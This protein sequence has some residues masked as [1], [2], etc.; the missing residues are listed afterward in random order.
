MATSFKLSEDGKSR[1]Y[2]DIPSSGFVLV[3]IAIGD[4]TLNNWTNNILCSWLE[5]CDT[6]DF[7]LIAIVDNLISLNSKYWKK[8]TWQ[9]L[10]IPEY[11]SGLNSKIKRVCYVDT[12]ILISPIAPDI[13]SKV[14]NKEI[15][16]V[17]IFSNLPYERK[18]VLDRISYFR[19][20]NSKGHYPLDSSLYM[21]VKQ[22]YEHHFLAVQPNYACMGLIVFDVYED[23]ISKFV[24]YYN[25]YETHVQSIT[26]GGDQTHINFHLQDDFKINWLEYKW[27]AIWA[28]EAAMKYP[29]AFNESYIEDQIA[30]IASSLSINYFLHFAGSWNESLIWKRCK[31]LY[32]DEIYKS[33]KDFNRIQ[34]IVRTGNP[35][36][37]VKPQLPLDLQDQ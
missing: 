6:Y 5:Y 36:G 21:S 37:M 16:L 3:T 19:N 11:L 10:L 29:S 25:F 27:Q 18:E 15:G 2:R 32:E 20:I 35:V 7:G 13:F 1:I 31:G 23:L 17:S 26:N 28:Y 9:K 34:Q 24:K 8:P 22:L 12:D 30:N 33:L 4:E 14:P